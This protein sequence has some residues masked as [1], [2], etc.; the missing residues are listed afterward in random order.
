MADPK[1]VKHWQ[2]LV[3]RVYELTAEVERLRPPT[4]PDGTQPLTTAYL[5][6]FA[7]YG[8]AIKAAEAS[9][10][11]SLIPLMFD[12]SLQTAKLRCGELPSN[13]IH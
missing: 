6:A 3:A 12:A 4:A 8:E 5:E 10:P 1:R 11:W 9:A 2:S 13:D 7:A